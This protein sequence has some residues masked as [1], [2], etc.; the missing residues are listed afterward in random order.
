MKKYV[1]PIMEVINFEK[2]EI[3]LTSGDI[4]TPIVPIEDDGN[5]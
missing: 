4:V 3:I 2:N 1:G 5:N